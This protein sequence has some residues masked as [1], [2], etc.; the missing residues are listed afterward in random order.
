MNQT[1][2][3]FSLPAT[4]TLTDLS[5]RT[6][7]RRFGKQVIKQPPTNNRALFPF[8]VIEPYLCVPVTNTDLP[9]LIQADSGDPA[10]QV[11]VALLFLIHDKPKHGAYWLELAAK[12]DHVDAMNLL[13]T[14]LIEGRGRRQD[15]N[16]GIMWIAKAAAL[17]HSLS[18][19]QMN[20]LQREG[21]LS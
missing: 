9:L 19:R 15:D 20:E 3:F 4:I 14:C 8:S 7:W 17:G 13:G 6:I 10:A 12:R 16:L 21:N 11:A 2:L 1:N 5:E 18:Q